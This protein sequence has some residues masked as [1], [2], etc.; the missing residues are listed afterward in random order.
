[1]P[2]DP[3]VTDYIARQQESRQDRMEQLHALL[4][5]RYP[6]ADVDMHDRM[7]AY[8]ICEGRGAMA[9][10]KKHLSLS[11]CVARHLEAFKAQYPD[12]PTAKGCINFRDRDAFDIGAIE[13]VIRHAIEHPEPS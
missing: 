4:L 7:L 1:M 13:S 6:G 12:I 8:R 3:E 10:R 9:N 5:D 11:T 2:V